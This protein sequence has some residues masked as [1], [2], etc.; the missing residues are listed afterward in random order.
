VGQLRD[1][2]TNEKA[3]KEILDHP[4]LT[5]DEKRFLDYRAAVELAPPPHAI[6]V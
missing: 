3:I 2:G 5:P 1:A 4:G 6:K